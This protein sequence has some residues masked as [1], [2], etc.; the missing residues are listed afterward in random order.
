MPEVLHSESETAVQQPTG[1]PPSGS[2]HYFDDH[3]SHLLDAQKA[4]IPWFKS[5]Y[6]NF[7][8]LIKPEKL[9][10]L[11]LTSKPV[12]VK[13]IWVFTR[14]IRSPGCIR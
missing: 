14:P 5:L 9:P 7:H 12:A 8:D 10:P 4:E 1:G 13:D 2:P 3:L 6:Q 11:E